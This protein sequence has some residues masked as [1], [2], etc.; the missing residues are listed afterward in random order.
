MKFR[1]GF[2]LLWE[3]S[4][5]GP[6]LIPF[7]RKD[8]LWLANVCGVVT[9]EIDTAWFYALMVVRGYTTINSNCGI[10]Y[11]MLKTNWNRIWWLRRQH[12]YLMHIHVIHYWNIIL[13]RRD[14]IGHRL[15]VSESRVMNLW[16]LLWSVLI[17]GWIIIELLT[18]IATFFAVATAIHTLWPGD[19]RGYSQLVTV[20]LGIWALYIWACA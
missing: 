12:W 3:K 2:T 14:W 18:E 5:H 7:W 16:F 13:L 8:R 6:V 17:W 20:N 10:S 11:G 4:H 1:R 19:R 9:C 15:S